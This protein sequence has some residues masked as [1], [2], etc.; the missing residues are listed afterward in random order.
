MVP[1][2][3][4]GGR[5][6]LSLYSF[7]LAVALGGLVVFH[8]NLIM[9]SFAVG[10][11]RGM[12]RNHFLDCI[13]VLAVFLVLA[14]HAQVLL[15]GAVGVSIFF[16]LSGYL[17]ATILLQ[18]DPS[19]A[20]LGKFV[21]RRFM[22]ISPLLWFQILLAVILT[23]VEAP[24]NLTN[25][26]HSVP[27]LLTFTSDFA[28]LG[29]VGM[30]RA[31]LWTLQ[32]E[33]WFYALMAMIVLVAGRNAL[34]WSALGGI[35]VAWFAKF[36]VGFGHQAVYGPIYPHV[37]YPLL[38]TIVYLDQLMI[39]VLCALVVQRGR[40]FMSAFI[41]SRV[42]GLWIPI[43]AVLVLSTLRFK[44]W[45]PGWY[46]ATSGA[47][48]FTAVMILHQWARPLKGDYEPLAT[49]GRISFSI[50][51]MHAVIFDFV[52]WHIFHFSLQV[53]FVTALTIVVSMGTY[54]WIEQP[55]VLWS[56]RVAKYEKAV[57]NLAEVPA[58]I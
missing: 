49:L 26:L 17:I 29:Y 12:D 56:K 39:G 50:Y 45:G 3:C 7:V 41:S 6:R 27:G 52:S 4:V 38:N 40:P 14:V 32:A 19:P 30:S 57:P 43:A 36:Y 42:F 24:E 9:S 31:V 22:R 8:V 44:G 1:S 25:Y 35:A 5:P 28:T 34:P 18:I 53:L 10:G 23:A 13:R 51:L 54:L 48:Y 11:A 37:L 21:F 16:C 33:F 15:G 55:F 20:N 58:P 2:I 47:A 46:F